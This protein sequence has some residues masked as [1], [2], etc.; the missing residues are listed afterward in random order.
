MN[1]LYKHHEPET[2]APWQL[3]KQSTLLNMKHHLPAETPDD[4]KLNTEVTDKFQAPRSNMNHI[5][6]ESERC[7]LLVILYLQSP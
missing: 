2:L 7:V 5:P 3:T 6:L 1:F 4:V